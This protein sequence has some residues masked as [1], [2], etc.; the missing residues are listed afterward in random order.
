MNVEIRDMCP[1][2]YDQKGYIHWKSWQETYT[3]LID[4]KFLENPSLEKCQTIAHRWPDNTL[5]A[6]IDNTVIG[7]GC[8][9]RHDDGCGEI[10]A[11]YILKEAQG[12]GIGRKLM[13]ALIECLSGCSFIMLWVLKGNEK[14]IGFYEHYGFRLNGVEKD[15]S[16]GIELQM[17]YHP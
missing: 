15:I 7:F 1:A 5:V 14:A 10:S 13:D 17:T 4:S 3:G 9:I 8:F 12:K 2:D 6:T 16:L 11:I